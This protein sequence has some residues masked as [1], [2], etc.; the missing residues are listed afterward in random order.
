MTNG[1]FQC[2]VVNTNRII[3]TPSHFAQS[4][5]LHIQE[6]GELTAQLPH[7]SERQNLSSYLF[8]LVENGS[9]TLTYLQN[10]YKL[11]K[12]DCVFIDCNSYYLHETNDDL[13]SLKWI[14]FQGPSMP[15]IYN[16]YLDRG[17][18]PT[19]KPQSTTLFN[20][21][22]ESIYSAAAS[23]DYI[24]DMKINEGLSS[25]LSLIMEHSW[26]QNIPHSHTNFNIQDVKTFLDDNFS[27]K[28]TLDEL[29]KRYFI[30]K[31]SLA[32]AFN[33]TYGISIINYV[34]QH[35]ITH[36]KKL[37][38][39]SDLNIEQIAY[40]CGYDSINYYSRVFK[41]VEGISPSEYRKNW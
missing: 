33:N 2:N 37:L 20:S 1:F 40:E 10:K 14:H 18:L 28:I 4:S 31:Y 5:L 16:K 30:N 39:F 8:F 3:Y 7:K 41:K 24:R 35:R 25:L 12:G 11:S 15:N 17:G 6:I 9:G 38:R 13:W 19:F 34:N 22:W 26:H 29:S 36:S 21:T 32:R 23:D 27:T